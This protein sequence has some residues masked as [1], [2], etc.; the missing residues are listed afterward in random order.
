MSTG[1]NQERI[2]QNNALLTTNNESLTALK[3]IVESL[4]VNMDT[5][6]AT[7]TAEDIAIGKTAYAN[8]TLVEGTLNYINYLDNATMLMAEAEVVDINGELVFT[9]QTTHIDNKSNEEGDESIPLDKGII[10][11]GILQVALCKPA[12]EVAAAIGLTAD[13]IKAG[14]TILGITG[15][16]E[17]EASVEQV[18][19]QAEVL[20]TQTTSLEELEEIIDSKL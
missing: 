3:T 19:E 15:T 17:G 12:N 16:Y 10:G 4:P 5:S 14:E 20:E 18:T 7:A 2:E 8:N 6:E 11:V 9:L 13:K 1:T